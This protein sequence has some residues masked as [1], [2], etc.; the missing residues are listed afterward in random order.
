MQFDKGYISPYFVTDLEAARD[1]LRRP[2]PA[3]HHAEDLGDRR[4]AAAAGE[5]H[6]ARQAAGHHRRGRRRRGAVDA[7]R[8]RDPQ[9]LHRG[10][11]QGAVLRR[12]PQGVP[13]GPRDRHRRPGRRPGGRPQARPGR[14]GRARPGGPRRRH[15]GHHDGH[16]RRRGAERR[17]TRG[18]R[19]SAA[20]SRTPTP[21]GIARSCRSGWPSS[22]AAWA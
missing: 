7:G 10:R 13:A 16:A 9:D 19:R 18:S 3:D 1:G 8:Q 12:P 17:S 21:T 20:R 2:V 11:G 4:P 6:R 22:P 15:Q 5:G 14:S